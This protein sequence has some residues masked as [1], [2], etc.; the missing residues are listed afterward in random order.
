MTFLPESRLGA[1]NLRGVS[2]GESHLCEFGQRLTGAPSNEQII[3]MV[4]KAVMSQFGSSDPVSAR[5]TIEQVRRT[6]NR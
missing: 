2:Y 4:R 6:F 3:E 1:G 5:F